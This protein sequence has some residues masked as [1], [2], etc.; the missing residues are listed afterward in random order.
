M[1]WILPTSI[2]EPALQRILL[3]ESLSWSSE[4]RSI[5]RREAEDAARRQSLSTAAG[6]KDVD[7]LGSVSKSSSIQSKSYSY[8]ILRPLYSPALIS[9][10]ETRD[11]K[12]PQTRSSRL[13]TRRVQ[14]KP[15]HN[16]ILLEAVERLPRRWT[17][18][19]G[20]STSECGHLEQSPRL[21]P[22]QIMNLYIFYYWSYSSKNTR[23]T[24]GSVI[25]TSSGKSSH[26]EPKENSPCF[27]SSF[28]SDSVMRAMPRS[29]VFERTF[30]RYRVS[31][32]TPYPP[33]GPSNNSRRT[34][35]PSCG[36]FS[37]RLSS[38]LSP[39]T[40]WTLNTAA[41]S[42]DSCRMRSLPRYNGESPISWD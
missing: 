7:K 1:V 27:S 3:L 33:V 20:N 28:I 15:S 34:M 6:P 35:K 30:T 39:I 23:S 38:V 13:E 2:P 40:A 14:R 37:P 18:R 16:E 36:S 31:D 22:S 41:D 19:K 5:S 11:A 26:W 25:S 4:S 21:A 42:T 8:S 17:I 24:S 32:L 29:W 10:M 9:C 12:N